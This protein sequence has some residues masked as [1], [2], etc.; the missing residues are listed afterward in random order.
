MTFIDN[1]YTRIYYM[2]MNKRNSSDKLS[3]LDGYCEFHH[4]IP[5]SLG[6]TNDTGN[7]VLLTAREHF[8]AH[9][10]LTKMVMAKNRTK[11]CWALHR[12]TYS[13]LTNERFNGRM[14]EW[15][16]KRH[17]D[18]MKTD[19][20]S[21]TPSWVQKVSDAVHSHW[22]NN[23]IRRSNTSK[24]MSQTWKEQPEILLEHN[25]KISILGGIASRE[26][27]A[28]RI[29]YNGVIHLGWN[30]LRRNTRVTKRLY[31]KYYMN[32][33]DPTPRIGANGP[34]IKG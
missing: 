21:K 30:E 2:L 6:G 18:F 16:R 10:L 15:Y 34:T 8:I 3:R 33:I 22:E 24:R 28:T 27:N 19:H 12:I 5:K 32:G 20:P 1:K 4:I 13:S 29:E 26:K 9:L 14:Y 23:D 7:L 11:M 25:R 17:S 31:Q